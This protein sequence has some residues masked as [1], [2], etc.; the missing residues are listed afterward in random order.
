MNNNVKKILCYNILSKNTCIY[1]NKCVFAHSYEEQIKDKYKELIIEFIKTNKDLSKI[2][3]FEDKNL[4]NELLIF[5]RECY[6][7]LIKACNGGY[8]CRYG[9]CFKNLKICKTDLISGDCKNSII[10][11]EFGNIKCCDGIHLTHKKLIPYNTHN[12]K[13]IKINNK[14]IRVILL[15]NNSIDQAIELLN[16]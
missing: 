10:N 3:I 14:N 4:Y 11:D 16:F 12:N 1:N 5:T 15:N 2:N 13:N 6:K 7:C 8:N 9:V